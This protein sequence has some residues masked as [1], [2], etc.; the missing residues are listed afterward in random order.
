MTAFINNGRGVEKEERNRFLEPELTC[1]PSL[2]VIYYLCCFVYYLLS[3]QKFHFN[4]FYLRGGR[5]RRGFPGKLTAIFK[6]RERAVNAH[7]KNER[8]LE[9]NQMENMLLLLCY[10]AT[11]FMNIYES[12]KSFA[13]TKTEPNS[14]P[15]RRETCLVLPRCLFYLNAPSSYAIVY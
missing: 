6:G 12:D 10:F 3:S 11:E 7:R 13:P 4:E 15:A 5:R 9:G 8:I 1:K 14:T 2:V